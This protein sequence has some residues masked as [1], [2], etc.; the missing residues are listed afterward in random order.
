MTAIH[1]F[2]AGYNKGDAISNEAR[3]LRDLFRK[4]GAAAEIFCEASC[5]HPEL[6]GDAKDVR[7]CRVDRRDIGL[8]HLSI[9][10][11][12]NEIFSRLRCRKVIRYHNITPPRYFETFQP[13]TAEQLRLGREQMERLSGAASVNLAVSRYNAKD[14]EDAGYYDVQV[15]PILLDFLSLDVKP[16]AG[17][18]NA[19][20]DERKNVLFVGRC[21]PNKCIDDLVRAF[22][23]YQRHVEPRSRLIHVGSFTG[24]EAY[25]GLCRI[26]ARNLGLRDVHFMGSVTQSQLTAFYRVADL[27][28][29]ASEHEGFCIPL[30]EC[31]QFGAPILAYAAAAIPETLDGSGILYRKK[32]IERIAEMMGRLTQDTPFRDA[33]L[34]GQS[35]RLRR[36]RSLDLEAKLRHHLTPLLPNG[37]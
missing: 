21:A 23:C 6:R 12:V 26:H 13:Q 3:L 11:E 22:A 34:D 19:Y 35:R 36:Y 14:L 32:D 9:G 18:L 28:L 15:L 37:L 1:Q 27:F 7:T 30:L 5:I 31:M 10:S 33:V 8:L 24:M 17:V 2:L 29:S 16:D 4:W 20:R 25:C